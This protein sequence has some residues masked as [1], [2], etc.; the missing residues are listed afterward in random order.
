MRIA[1]S[2][3]IKTNDPPSY[4]TVVLRHV[5]IVRNKSYSQVHIVTGH[6]PLQR[7]SGSVTPR[8]TDV[9]HRCYS[10]DAAVTHRSKRE[11][12]R[13]T[14]YLHNNGSHFSKNM[15]FRLND[16]TCLFFLQMIIVYLV[17]DTRQMSFST[18]KFGKF[19]TFSIL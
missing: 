2:K 1:T 8:L 13:N 18:T 15:A 19:K 9:G 10:A 3:M 17:L 12:Y 14:Q 16:V 5:T 6:L 4:K 7:R 11:P